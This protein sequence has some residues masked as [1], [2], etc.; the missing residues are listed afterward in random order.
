MKKLQGF[1]L[2]EVIIVIVL[3]G[4]LGGAIA[5]FIY[6]LSQIVI[7]EYS[8]GGVNTQTRVAMERMS[9]ELRV[10]RSN[11]ST[12]LTAG[13]SSISFNTINGDAISF[14]LSSTNLMRNS[15]I[16]ASNVSDITFTYYDSSGATTATVTDMKFIR[17][18]LT[19]TENNISAN[20]N[21]VVYPSSWG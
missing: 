14:S 5:P 8:L 21:T 12:D 20:L 6:S 10:I 18:D 16:L 1:T 17:V 15:Q 11:T 9:R 3:M 19:L 4:I 7:V 13:A 2:I